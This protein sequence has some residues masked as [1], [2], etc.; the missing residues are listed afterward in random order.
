MKLQV[1]CMV[2]SH[3]TSEFIETSFCPSF[4]L[5]TPICRGY[6]AEGIWPPVLPITAAERIGWP[7]I[8]DVIAQKTV[9]RWSSVSGNQQVIGSHVKWPSVISHCRSRGPTTNAHKW[10]NISANERS[11]GR[12]RKEG[13]WSAEVIDEQ[14]ESKV[15]SG[16]SCHHHT[17]RRGFF[18][19]VEFQFNGTN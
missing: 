5:L 9:G 19:E 15:P 12:E 4:V 17:F 13:R 8:W 11:G 3:C 6:V 10:Y 7:Y 18:R 14:R 1:M 16:L 2:K